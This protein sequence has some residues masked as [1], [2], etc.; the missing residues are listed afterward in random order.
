[1]QLKS[2]VNKYGALFAKEGQNVTKTMQEDGISEDDIKEVLS[3]IAEKTLQDNKNKAPIAASVYIEVE[4]I[5]KE[6]K[7]MDYTNL[8]YERF[9]RYGELIQQLP[10]RMKFDFEVIKVTAI[11]EPRYEGVKD[12]PIDIIGIQIADPK[13]KHTTRIPTSLAIMQNG[14]IHWAKNKKFFE[15][16]GAQFDQRGNGLFYFIKK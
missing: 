10:I 11:K 2:A 7:A 9:A 13:P 1:M 5:L 8:T 6:I 14:R 12:S 15:V 4:S 3:A 16:I